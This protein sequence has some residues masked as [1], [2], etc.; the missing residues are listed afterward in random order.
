MLPKRLYEE[1]VEKRPNA[2]Y[3][4]TVSDESRIVIDNSLHPNKH[5][6]PTF[7]EVRRAAN[8]RDEDL[9]FKQD[10]RDKGE[11]TGSGWIRTARTA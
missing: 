1:L 11:E 2:W 8:V 9:R 7:S 3:D 6:A 10:M 5:L 4:R